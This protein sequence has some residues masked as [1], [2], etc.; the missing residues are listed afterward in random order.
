M[1]DHPYPS[2]QPLMRAA[3]VS[4]ALL[5]MVAYAVVGA[6]SARAGESSESFCQGGV[7]RAYE[8]PLEELPAVRESPDTSKLTWA[9][10]RLSLYREGVLVVAGEPIL[11]QLTLGGARYGD[12]RLGWRIESR[13]VR[14]DR[15]GRTVGLARRKT[16]RFGQAVSG[17]SRHF[18]FRASPPPGL[19]R[20]DISFKKGGTTLGR[21]S[22]YYRVVRRNTEF[23]LG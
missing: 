6:T 23:G 13:L 5:L 9:S 1:S 15:H 11:Y 22:D 21:Y 18:G 20:F 4:A 17:E 7:L 14:V 8:A 10:K 16:D 3:A 12:L 2:A 19:Y